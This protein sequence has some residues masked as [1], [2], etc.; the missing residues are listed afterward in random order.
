MND[1]AE[2]NGLVKRLKQMVRRNEEGHYVAP[3]DRD[4]DRLLYLASREFKYGQHRF[5]N[6]KAL[7]VF[8]REYYSDKGSGPEG[9]THSQAIRDSL[10]A[11][12]DFAIKSPT[13]GS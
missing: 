12:Y 5:T 3:K 13:L 2:L 10:R 4:L 9:R 8:K 1:E 11:V 6:L 7:D